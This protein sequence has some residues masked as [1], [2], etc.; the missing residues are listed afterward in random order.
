ML[1]VGL[2]SRGIQNRFRGIEALVIS[3]RI[4]FSGMGKKENYGNYAVLL[5]QMSLLSR[6]GLWFCSLASQADIVEA[7]KLEHEYPHAL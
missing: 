3:I 5:K 7:R 1:R 4:G 2:F 6:V